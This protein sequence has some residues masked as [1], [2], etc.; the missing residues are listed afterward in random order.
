MEPADD[1]TRFPQSTASVHRPSVIKSD[2][3]DIINS[4]YLDVV[5]NRIDHL[6]YYRCFASVN[7]EDLEAASIISQDKLTFVCKA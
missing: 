3:G 6:H 2:C 7:H 1:R 4:C 5:R